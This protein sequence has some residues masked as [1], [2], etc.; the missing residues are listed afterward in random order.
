[1]TGFV[2]QS[3]PGAVAAVDRLPS[4]DRAACRRSFETRF[5]ASRMAREY[6]EIYER[7]I[8][9]AGSLAYAGGSAA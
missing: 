3:I 6:V 9:R 5:T 4:I 7:L 2:V 8:T 1:M